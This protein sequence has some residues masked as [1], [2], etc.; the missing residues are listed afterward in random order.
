MAAT[1]GGAATGF[2][3]AVVTQVRSKRASRR[4]SETDVTERYDVFHVHDRVVYYGKRSLCCLRQDSTLRRAAVWV[5]AHPWFEWFILL[6]IVVNSALLGVADYSAVADDGTL[7]PTSDRNRVVRA[8]EPIFNA[9]FGAEMVSTV[10]TVTATAL[11]RHPGPSRDRRC[12]RLWRWG[13]WPCPART[14]ATV[15]TCWIVS[16]P[17]WRC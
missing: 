6:A 12:S 1:P 15:G 13:S 7:L 2:A 5:I 14:C 8:S 17:R 3:T 16:S 10:N 11:R 4:L 9:I